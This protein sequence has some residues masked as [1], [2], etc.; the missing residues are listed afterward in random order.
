MEP[1]LYILFAAVAF[2]YASVGHGGA[3]GY[4]A[5]MVLFAF[6]QGEIKTNALILNLLVS[7]L[8]FVQYY[9]K[10]DFPWKLFLLLALFSMPAAFLGGT[11]TL[12]DKAFKIILGIVLLVP[13]A[14]LLGLLPVRSFEVKPGI[15]L[16]VLMGAGIGLLSGLLG[17]GGGIIL[18]PILILLG[19]CTVK[20]TSAVSA[21]FIFVNSLSGLWGKSQAELHFSGNLGHIALFTVMGGL[22][23][24]YLG[25]QKF[26]VEWVRHL[27]A[28]V[29]VIASYKLCF[30]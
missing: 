29:L 3:S 23:G 11:M 20:Q 14:K 10:G 9:R 30:T 1:V 19:W 15:G 16:I 13:I 4:I 7:L 22:A 27:L 24:A 5:L 26:K 25:S 8:A 18:S 2:L 6:P 28:L 21:L 17:I 12:H